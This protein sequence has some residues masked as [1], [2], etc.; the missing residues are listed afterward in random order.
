MADQGGEFSIFQVIHVRFDIRIDIS[1]YH[2]TYDHQIWQSCKSAR[3]DS[4]D[5]CDKLKT[6]VLADI[7]LGRMVTYLDPLLPIKS[8]DPLIKL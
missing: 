2:N 3:F 4:N 7:K 1:I 5:G 8:Y 6:R